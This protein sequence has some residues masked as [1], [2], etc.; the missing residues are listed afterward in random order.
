[1]NRIF[2]ARDNEKYCSAF[3]P[4]DEVL[5]NNIKQKY[6]YY[7]YKF[8]NEDNDVKLVWYNQINY[9]RCGFFKCNKITFADLSHIIIILD[10]VSLNVTK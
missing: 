9:I 10:V 6:V 5:I 8:E 7:E 1:M 2:Y 3:I 4:P